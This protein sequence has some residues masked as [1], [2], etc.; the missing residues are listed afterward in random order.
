M[1]LKEFMQDH[2]ELLYWNVFLFVED[3]WQSEWQEVTDYEDYLDIDDFD[4]VISDECRA[5]DIFL[6]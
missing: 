5:C 1:T 6:N 3:E 4:Y 2:K